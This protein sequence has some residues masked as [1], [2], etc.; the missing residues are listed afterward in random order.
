MTVSITTAALSVTIDD[1]KLT[2]SGTASAEFALSVGKGDA[3]LVGD[4]KTDLNVSGVTTVSATQANASTE[5]AAKTAAEN[6]VKAITGW[7]TLT[8]NGVTAS[9]TNGAFTAA[10]TGTF[11][12]PNGT[13]GSYTFKVTLTKG[14]VTNSDI[15]GTV[16]ITATAASDAQLVAGA[17]SEL[18]VTSV[19]A[20]T[21]AMASVNTNTDAATQVENAIKALWSS[22]LT[23]NSVTAS[24]SQVGFTAAVAGSTSNP[25]PWHGG[26]LY[27]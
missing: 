10:Q 21:V 6:A 27:V 12:T 22:S 7:T 5:T 9:I 4:A 11:G 26:I 1:L 19:R 25:P 23:K 13:D 18:N 24:V 3:E 20:I 15:G 17:K 8:K 2:I 16:T 14:A